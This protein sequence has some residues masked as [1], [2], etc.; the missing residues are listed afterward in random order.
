MDIESLARELNEIIYEDQVEPKIKV[1]QRVNNHKDRKRIFE[2]DKLV[3][4]V[5]RALN[6]V[7]VELMLGSQERRRFD[8]NNAGVHQGILGN[9]RIQR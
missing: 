2:K 6:E 7:I 8:E 9:S 4:G 5:F 3:T 1:F